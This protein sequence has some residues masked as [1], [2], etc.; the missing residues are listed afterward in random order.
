MKSYGS[1]RLFDAFR[2]FG[3]FDGLTYLLTR[4]ISKV[5]NG[6]MSLVRYCIY[7]QPVLETALTPPRRGR[8]IA[9][10][11]ASEETALNTDFG[12][13]VSVVAD[14]L[15]QGARCLL[16]VRGSN[17]VGFQWFTTQHYL[18]DEVRCRFEITPAD[19][20]AWDFDIYVAP[21]ERMRP[22]FSLLWDRCNAELRLA[23]IETCLSRISTYNLSSKKSHERLGAK[24]VG[25]LACLVAGRSQLT[26][27][28]AW[29]WIHVSLSSKTMPTFPASRIA[30][31]QAA[32]SGRRQQ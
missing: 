23:G 9:I 1:E 13:P 26:I 10:L 22:V 16:A 21:E 2:R 7:A 12:R 31:Q 14:R 5:S 30:S 24:Q 18:E 27:M 25:W 15:K 19:H 4:A 29:P 6:R 3:F 11:E 17:L 8:D 32:C 20:C 28:S